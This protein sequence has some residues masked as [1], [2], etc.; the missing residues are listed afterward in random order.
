MDTVW[1]LIYDMARTDDPGIHEKA[2][3]LATYALETD[4]ARAETLIEMAQAL[5]AQGHPNA[6]KLIT[7]TICGRQPAQSLCQETRG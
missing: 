4:P 5:E 1:S 2:R 7:E 3:A 6:A